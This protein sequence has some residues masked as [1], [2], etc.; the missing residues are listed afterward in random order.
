MKN[1][2]FTLIELLAVIILLALIAVITIPLVSKTID[3]SESKSDYASISIYM[4]AVDAAILNA[5]ITGYFK[6]GE[7]V[8]QTSGNLDC[9]GTIINVDV[10]NSRPISGYIYVEDRRVVEAEELRIGDNYYNYYYDGTIEK[11]EH[12]NEEN[13]D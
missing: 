7:C 6:D 2:G 10:E 13:L 12:N 5:N 9:D 3:N 11:V 8:V 4:K 1:K